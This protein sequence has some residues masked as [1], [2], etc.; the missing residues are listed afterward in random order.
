[1]SFFK[2]IGRTVKKAAN[3]T[4][5]G[6]TETVKK[7]ASKATRAVGG[8][9]SSVNSVQSTVGGVTAMVT[10]KQPAIED[11][12]DDTK[13]IVPP[14]VVTPAV[15]E[16]AVVAKE[17]TAAAPDPVISEMKYEQA[18]KPVPQEVVV[19]KAATKSIEFT[20]TDNIATAATTDYQTPPP[21]ARSVDAKANV[22]PVFLPH[23]IVL[24]QSPGTVLPFALGTT[25]LY[26]AMLSLIA[27]LSYFL[28]TRRYR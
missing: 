11:D 23:G 28:Y 4:T 1:M 6:V 22:P 19:S 24:Q 27:A 16:I 2:K 25:S 8:A 13:Q 20:E 26:V 10:G 12:D 5:K 7:T 21:M 17:V 9:T 15:S 3:A 14:P 18:T